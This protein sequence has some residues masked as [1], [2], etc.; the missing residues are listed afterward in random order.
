MGD[1]EI[2]NNEYKYRTDFLFSSP[3]FIQGMGT[4]LNLAGHSYDFNYSNSPQEAD[5]KAIRNDWGMIGQDFRSIL[6]DPSTFL[7][8]R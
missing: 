3:S 5:F 1:R 6:R 7:N 4:V 8:G 2:L